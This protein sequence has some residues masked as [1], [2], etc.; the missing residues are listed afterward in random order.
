MAITEKNQTVHQKSSKT[1]QYNLDR[2]TA[3]ISA[4]SSGNVSKYEFFNRKRC[5]TGKRLARKSCCNQNI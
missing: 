1:A 2:K 4:S 3:K 5:S